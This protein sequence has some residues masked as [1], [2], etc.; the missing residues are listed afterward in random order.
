MAAEEDSEGS[1]MGNQEICE[2]LSVVLQSVKL[3]LDRLLELDWLNR[4]DLGVTSQKNDNIGSVINDRISLNIYDESDIWF[5]R[6]LRGSL[7]KYN[8]T[9]AALPGGR[10]L[11]IISV[12]VVFLLPSLAFVSWLLYRKSVVSTQ[13]TNNVRA[14]WHLS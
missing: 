3:V 4:Q 8:G 10:S 5:L 7:I 1:I 14:R 6:I 13:S 12:S 11:K 2:G 9:G